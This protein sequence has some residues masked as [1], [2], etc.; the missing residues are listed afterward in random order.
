[1]SAGSLTGQVTRTEVCR[2]N[3]RNVSR[4]VGDLRQSGEQK[5][6]S[7]RL[8]APTR[9]LHDH[10]YLVYAGNTAGY[11]V[12]ASRLH[13][14]RPALCLLYSDQIPRRR[15]R[16]SVTEIATHAWH[17]IGTSPGTPGRTPFR[18]SRRAPGTICRRRARDRHTAA[19]DAPCPNSLRT[20]DIPACRA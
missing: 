2:A 20:T 9:P 5:L 14:T 4:M 6:F 11:A 13:T 1:M 18:S 7:G 19:A 3:A 10:E 15:V 8:P 12:S 16:W 17:R